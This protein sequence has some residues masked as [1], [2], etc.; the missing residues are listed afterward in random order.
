VKPAQALQATLEAEHAAVH[1]YGVLGGRLAASDNPVSA[2]RLRD[3]YDVHRGRRDQLR[4][5]IADTGGTPSP[6]AA[7]YAVDAENRDAG[8]LLSVAQET[9]ERCATVYAQL[10]GSSSGPHRRWAVDAL[11][12]A[13]VRQ[14]ELGGRATAY[15]GLPELD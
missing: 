9:E 11:T 13:A 4:S 8:H 6:A 1:V 5:L 15:P 12:D 3:A 14:L 7:A 2:D 10:V